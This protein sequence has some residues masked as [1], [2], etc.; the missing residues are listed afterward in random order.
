[1]HREQRAHVLRQRLGGR[2]ELLEIA[3]LGCEHQVEDLLLRETKR[4]FRQR[5]GVV[6]RGVA[7]RL[8]L[9]GGESDLLDVALEPAAVALERGHADLMAVRGQPL[10]ELGVAG[11]AALNQ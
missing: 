1:M 2:S 10:G 11:E 8:R 6:G 7:K 9:L 5:E 3:L 4:G